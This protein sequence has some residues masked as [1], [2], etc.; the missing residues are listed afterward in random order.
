MT[1][2]T[3][4]TFERPVRVAIVGSGPSGFFAADSLLKQKDIHVSIDIIDRLPTPYGLVRY[5]VAPDHQKIKS[6]TKLYEKTCNDPR[7]RFI[8]NVHFGTD[9]SHE[10]V[11]R[12]YDAVVYAVGASADR[13]LNIP[14]EDLAGSLSATEFVAWYNGHPDYAT[15]DPDLS[16]E[17]VAV[18]GMG[19]VAVDVTRILAK[20]VDELRKTDIA[21][22]ALDLLAESK[23]KNIYMIGRRGPAQAKF[24]TKELRELGELENA[25]INVSAEDLDLDPISEASL[26]GNP[27]LAKNI[28]VLRGFAEQER[29]GK[30]RCVHLRFF[31]SPVELLGETQVEELRLEK[32]RLEDQNGYL[33]AAG[34]GE[35]ETLPIG[36]ILRSVGYKGTPL[37]DVPFD[38]RKNIIPNQDGRVTDN[39]G[40]VVR[41][42]Y[43]AGWI[44]RGP[45][46]VIGTNKA[47]AMESVRCLL[48]DVPSL[49]PVSE[50]AASP[51]A[52]EEILA[53]KQVSFVTF[54]DWLEI[55]R[56]ETQAGAEQG[57]PR[58]K[59]TQVERMV[60]RAKTAIFD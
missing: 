55:D 15:L 51:R 31:E 45:S 28:E 17:N 36:M 43:V 41:G 27:A 29:T 10:E 44:K 33:N 6:V 34:T 21:D 48:E 2:S 47:D 3:L 14:G 46:G 60:E 57:R 25:D 9:L 24:T 56:L 19:N 20:S 49:E 52:V 32:N 54:E 59:I 50:H 8:G 39:D 11:R 22:H 35:F 18:I 37:K 5:G 13:S 42:E 23:V 53:S 12:F 38:S 16:T 7:V 40:N 1:H 30:P 26:K 4:G 58:V